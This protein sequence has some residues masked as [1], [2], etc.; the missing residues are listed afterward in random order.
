MF[1]KRSIT[2]PER[3]ALVHQFGTTGRLW[4]IC[5]KKCDAV[6]L[7]NN[8]SVVIVT[9]LTP[10]IRAERTSQQHSMPSPSARSRVQTTATIDSAS[11]FNAAS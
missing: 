11:A 8:D 7:A 9:I 4:A 3:D 1:R 6:V 10:D 2:R 5:R